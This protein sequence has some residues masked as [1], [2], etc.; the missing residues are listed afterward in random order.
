MDGLAA[1]RHLIGTG[2]TRDRIV[3]EGDVHRTGA[4]A[5]ESEWLEDQIKVAGAKLTGGGTVTGNPGS[6]V[7]E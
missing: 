7:S 1:E 5:R 6:P 4:L 3:D 2:S